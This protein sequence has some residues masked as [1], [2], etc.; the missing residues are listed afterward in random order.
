MYLE[1]KKCVTAVKVSNFS[2][3]Y[4]RDRSTLDMGVLGYIGILY[5]TEHPPLLWH[6]PLGTPYISTKHTKL[7][8]YIVCCM[9]KTH[10]RVRNHVITK[11]MPSLGY[12]IQLSTN[13]RNQNWSWSFFTTDGQSTSL[14]WSRAPIWSSWPDFCFLSDNCGFLDVGRPVWREDGSVIYSYDCFWALAEQPLSGPS[15]SELRPYFC[16]TFETPPTWTARW[17]WIPSR[18]C[19]GIIQQWRNSFYHLA[20][21]QK[22]TVN[23]I[24]SLIVLC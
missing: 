20:C 18:N 15:P 7:Y 12:Y 10:L 2:G 11:I 14:S 4:L 13:D 22:Y 21:W 5:H 19:D 16:F 3:H 6:I 9:S 8:V 23:F 17:I 1:I 24:T